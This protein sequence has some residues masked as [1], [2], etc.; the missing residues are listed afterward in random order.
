MTVAKNCNSLSTCWRASNI[1]TCIRSVLSRPLCTLILDG[2]QAAKADDDACCCCTNW[3]CTVWLS[4]FSKYDYRQCTIIAY[5]VHISQSDRQQQQ[6]G[7]VGVWQKF[8]SNSQHPS[9]N[10]RRCNPAGSYVCENP[11]AN[12]T[13]TWDLVICWMLCCINRPRLVFFSYRQ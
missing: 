6:T 12:D 4:L 9:R 13:H 7:V 11:R 3:L 5:Y 10:R 2:T 1:T 8:Q